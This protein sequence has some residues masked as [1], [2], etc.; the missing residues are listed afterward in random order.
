MQM[1]T[2]RGKLTIHMSRMLLENALSEVAR[3]EKAVWSIAAERCKEAQVRY[4]QVL[5]FIH[6]G[7]FKRR[8]FCFRNRRGQLCEKLG[9][10]NEPAC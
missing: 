8:G 9:S 4:G 2:A 1:A 10:G 3:E 5:C 7:E 6:D